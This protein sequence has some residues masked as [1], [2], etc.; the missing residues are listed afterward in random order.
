MNK[1]VNKRAANKQKL[2]TLEWSEEAIESCNRIQQEPSILK[3]M[4]LNREMKIKEEH[5]QLPKLPTLY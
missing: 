2:K 1:K 3:N 4:I 5:L